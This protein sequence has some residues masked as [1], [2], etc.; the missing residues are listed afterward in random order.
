VAHPKYHTKCCLCSE[1]QQR[2]DPISLDWFIYP[3]LSLAT[4]DLVTPQVFNYRH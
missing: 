4:S 1:L 2:L 3:P